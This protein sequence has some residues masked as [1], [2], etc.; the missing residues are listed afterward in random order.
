MNLQPIFVAFQ[1]PVQYI[2]FVNVIFKVI[3]PMVAFRNFIMY[4]YGRF[5]GKP[6]PVNTYQITSKMENCRA[7]ESY[8]SLVG[9]HKY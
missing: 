2:A 7:T 6:G 9:A 1:R 3:L 8:L 5:V 4:V